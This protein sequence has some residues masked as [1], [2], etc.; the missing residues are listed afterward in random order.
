LKYWQ[1]LSSGNVN[2]ESQLQKRA[3]PVAGATGSY[4]HGQTAAGCQTLV[5]KSGAT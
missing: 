2:S 3:G 4:I 1:T 5:W